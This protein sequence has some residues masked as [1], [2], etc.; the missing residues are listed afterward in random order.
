MIWPLR[1]RTNHP[2]PEL[3]FFVF[4]SL[5]SPNK[6]LLL[7]AKIL[8]IQTRLLKDSCHFNA[9][10]GCFSEAIDL[11]KPLSY[12]MSSRKK[13]GHYGILKILPSMLNY[14]CVFL[15]QIGWRH[16]QITAILLLT[17]LKCKW[18]Y[19]KLPKSVLQMFL[20]IQHFVEAFFLYL[21][22]LYL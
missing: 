12:H 6:Q 21:S 16:T 22:S 13:S 9:L 4:I 19:P 5:Q 11:T 2:F 7:A 15:C 1:K 10:C 20:F 18:Q 8:K 14:N 3:V 17:H